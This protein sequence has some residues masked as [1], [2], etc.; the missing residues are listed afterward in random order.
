MTDHDTGR[1]AHAAG[2]RSARSRPQR[3]AGYVVRRLRPDEWRELRD[4][5]LRALADAPDAFG[6]RLEEEQ[7]VGEEDWRRWAA[8]PDRIVVVAERDGRLFGMASGG[9]APTEEG[10]VAGLYSMW[11]EAEARGTGVAQAIVAG[12]MGW[13]RDRG[14]TTIGLGVTTSNGRAIALY[15]RLGFADTGDRYPLR[16]GAG[17]EIQIMTRGL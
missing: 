4:L 2:G 8:S 14:Y 1:D 3:I 15:E 5:R 7:A 16:E 9:R 6:A 13:A 11:V 17:L 10:V 12:V